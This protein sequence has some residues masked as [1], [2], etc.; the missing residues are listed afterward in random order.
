MENWGFEEQLEQKVQVGERLTPGD[1]GPGRTTPQRL[2]FQ[3]GHQGSPFTFT[4][5]SMDS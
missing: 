4:A 3:A 1:G 2:F 5:D